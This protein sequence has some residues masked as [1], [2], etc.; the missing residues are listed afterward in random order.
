MTGVPTSYQSEIITMNQTVFQTVNLTVTS[1]APTKRPTI[2]LN[3]EVTESET[4]MTIATQSIFTSNK[5]NQTGPLDESDPYSTMEMLMNLP[6]WTY[7]IAGGVTMVFMIVICMLV[8]HCYNQRTRN[9]KMNEVIFKDS[10]NKPHMGQKAHSRNSQKFSME[11]SAHI[12][13][14][15]ISAEQNH[16]LMNHNPLARNG[17]IAVNSNSVQMNGNTNHMEY[18]HDTSGYMI[19]NDVSSSDDA[20]LSVEGLKQSS[21]NKKSRHKANQALPMTQT[22]E[23][24]NDID[25]MNNQVSPRSSGNINEGDV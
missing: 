17:L 9:K 21:T 16:N 12:V 11:Q 7:L 19:D 6:F 13:D 23:H 3:V 15:K 4:L 25:P 5:I 2:N 10:S 14:I 8:I 22:M 20:I 18:I 1:L 24:V